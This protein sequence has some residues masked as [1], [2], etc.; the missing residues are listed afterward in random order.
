MSGR[1]HPAPRFQFL[2][3]ELAAKAGFFEQAGHHCPNRDSAMA[4]AML[5]KAIKGAAK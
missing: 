1:R 2:W 3:Q 5:R 4:A